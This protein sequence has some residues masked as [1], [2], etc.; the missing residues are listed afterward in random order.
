MQQSV[1]VDVVEIDPV[2]IDYAMQFFNFPVP[3]AVY[4]EDGREYIKNAPADTYDYVLH[5]VFTGGS[6]PPHLFSL[7]AL[8]HIKRI[9]KPDGI[10]S[11]VSTICDIPI[12]LP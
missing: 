8:Q 5:D 6:A 3:R 1:L 9:M 12:S 7:E 11:V 10:L 4:I 2:V